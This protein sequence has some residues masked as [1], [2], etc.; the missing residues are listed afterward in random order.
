MGGGE[1]SQVSAP[2]RVA[3]ARDVR[4]GLRSD[5]V[6]DLRAAFV[7][8]GNEAVTPS[9]TQAVSKA[10][11]AAQLFVA[12]GRVLEAKVAKEV[13]IALAGRGEIGAAHLQRSVLVK[14]DEHLVVVATA[15]GEGLALDGAGKDALP[16][17][18]EGLVPALLVALDGVAQGRGAVVRAALYVDRGNL[19]DDAGLVVR[20]AVALDLDVAVL[21]LDARQG[22][23]ILQREDA[24][25]D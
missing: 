19:C 5:L 3:E 4:T 16:I 11:T 20:A 2:W 10:D 14:V 9:S 15:R 6:R 17:E 13:D 25:L 18:D 22:D 12:G 7:R 8:V 21:L 23:L 1:L 24:E